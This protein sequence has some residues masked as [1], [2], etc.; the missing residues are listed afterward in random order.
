MSIIVSEIKRFCK[1]NWRVF[2]LFLICLVII[3]LTH[4]WDLVEIVLVFVAHFSADLAIMLM[5]DYFSLYQK[6]W[7]KKYEKYALVAQLVSFIIFGLI[8]LYAWI[9]WWKWAYFVPQVLFIWP[10]LKQFWK[11][12]S[13]KLL[14]KIWY[15]IIL[16]VGIL[17]I[18]W[19][20]Y[21]WLIHN[22]WWLIQVLGFV[23]FPLWLSLNNAKLRYFVSTI[24]IGLIFIGS[25]YQLIL[26]I[27]LK[28]VSWVDVSYTLLPFVVFVFYLK[29]IK[30][31]LNK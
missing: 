6:T 15:K 25:L 21:F 30:V 13:I 31:F 29:N 7:D 20:F 23:I 9:F 4:S 12:Y 28:D 10:L 17:T 19:Y 2:V 14:E 11:I 18:F 5:W 16:V 3:Y 8:W 24:W 22:V 26:W 1:E 27:L